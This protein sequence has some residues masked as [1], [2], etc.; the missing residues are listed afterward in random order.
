[1]SGN[2]WFRWAATGTRTLVGTVVAVAFTAL[3]VTGVSAPWPV[4]TE[5]VPV[6]ET[7]PDA[8]D[9]VAVCTGPVLALGRT[10]EDA[11]QITVAEASAV[12]VGVPEG[13]PEPSAGFLPSPGVNGGPGAPFFVAEP[14]GGDVAI[15]SA[16]SSAAV[17]EPDL[18]GFAAAACR[19]PLLE[20]WI[21][22]GTTTTGASDI[23]LLS[24]PGAVTAS[25]Q[26]TVFGAEGPQSPPGAAG[27]TVPAQSQLALPL[28]AVAGGEER[29]VVRVTATGAPVAASLQSSLVRTLVPGG[30]DVQGAVAGADATQVFAGV[31]VLNAPTA[32]TAATVV[33][34][35]SPTSDT[36]VTLSATPVG[37]TAPAATTTLP[38]TAGIPA[39]VELANLSEGSYVLTAEAEAPVVSA[40]WQTAGTGVGSDFAWYTP[41]PPLGAPTLFAVPEGPSPTLTLANRGGETATAT[42][43]SAGRADQEIVVPAQGAV[44]VALEPNAIYTLDAG[45]AEAITGGVAFAEPGA[46]AGLPVWPADA[47]AEPVIVYP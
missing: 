37:S 39:E 6:V 15:L 28:A 16:A 17:A 2:R 35:L 9:T 46:L 20:S 29:P 10:V 7:R 40:A 23:L 43:R 14:E 11:R 36:N 24:N 47:G 38:L 27:I 41:S 4:V 1:M 3:V 30:I 34:V 19:P 31:T 32:G 45:G 8:A 25:V 18:T 42:L 13:A 26:L 5:P 21:V 33:R 44:D 12:T 22:G